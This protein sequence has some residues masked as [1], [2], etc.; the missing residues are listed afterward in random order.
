VTSTPEFPDPQPTAPYLLASLAKPD[1]RQVYVFNTTE[2][3][4]FIT[5]S[6]N[7]VS[8]DIADDPIYG[9]VSVLLYIDY[10]FPDNP[11]PALPYLEVFESP[12]SPLEPGSLEQ[13]D[14]RASVNW[15]PNKSLLGC[16]T[17]T[18]VASH[19]FTGG[20]RCPADANDYSM[21]TWQV[22][23]C[24]SSDGKNGCDLLDLSACKGWSRSCFEHG[25]DGGTSEGGLP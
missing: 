18:M 24:D 20:A 22:F 4:S 1:P 10:G 3:T 6:A 12:N 9:H 19:R 17:A 21:I 11:N 8:Q 5:F 23:V 25:L 16:H 7:V 15:Y 13:T 14:R 2:S